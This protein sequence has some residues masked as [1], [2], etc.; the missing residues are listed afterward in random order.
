MSEDQ[1]SKLNPDGTNMG[2]SM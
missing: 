2:Q 1:L